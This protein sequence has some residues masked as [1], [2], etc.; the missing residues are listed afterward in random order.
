MTEHPGPYIDVDSDDSFLD[1]P[2]PEYEG[3]PISGAEIDALLEAARRGE[4]ELP[5]AAAPIDR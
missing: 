2:E 3:G 5:M 4:V 1:L